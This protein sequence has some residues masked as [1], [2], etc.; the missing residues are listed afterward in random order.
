[1]TAAGLL[2]LLLLAPMPVAATEVI[3]EASGLMPPVLTVD[4]D[5]QV[6]F[7]NRSGCT[8]HVEFFGRTDGHHVFQVPGR[9]RAIFH[10]PG[11]HPYVAHFETKPRGELRGFV[12]VREQTTPRGDPPVC[13]GITVEENCLEP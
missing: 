6:S 7:V 10:R 1:V 4:A 9:I 11:R 3:I 8:V 5:E 2:A 12:D 13:R